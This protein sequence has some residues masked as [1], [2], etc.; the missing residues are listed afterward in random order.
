ML[1]SLT[2][3][4][5][6]SNGLSWVNTGFAPCGGSDV[7]IAPKASAAT[8]DF[9]TGIC[10]CSLCFDVDP[11][12]VL[13]LYVDRCAFT[14]A[15][16]GLRTLLGRPTASSNASAGITMVGAKSTSGRQ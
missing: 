9:V 14:G 13:I 15:L 10:A 16:A 3:I 2:E 11:V 4:D 5:K 8:I 7:L 1:Y 12:I 6:G